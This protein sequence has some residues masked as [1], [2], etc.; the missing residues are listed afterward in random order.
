[1]AQP[2]WSDSGVHL[3]ANTYLRTPAFSL[4]GTQRAGSA[5]TL[6]AESGYDY[7]TWNTRSTAAAPECRPLATFN[8]Y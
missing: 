3:S 2:A 6:Q 8:S 1:M 5:G 7:V 4:S